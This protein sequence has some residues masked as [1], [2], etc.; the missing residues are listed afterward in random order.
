MMDFVE[1]HGIKK[2]ESNIV[3]TE[4]IGIPAVGV[5]SITYKIGNL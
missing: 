2:F 5:K 4:A 3:I 1:K